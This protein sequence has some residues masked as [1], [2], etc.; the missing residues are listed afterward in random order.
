MSAKVIV[1]GVDVAKDWHYV[2]AITA[3]SGVSVE[4]AF[5]ISNDWSGFDV[6]D[7]SLEAAARARRGGRAD[8]IVGMEPTGVY[9]QPLAYFLEQMGYH[10]VYVNPFAV[11]Q[12]KEVADNTPVKSDPKDALVI[13][14][15][16]RNGHYLGM[17][18]P[19]GVYADMRSLSDTHRERRKDR[20]RW[21]N[22]M[23][24]A[25]AR[26][27]PEFPTVMRTLDSDCAVW[28]LKNAPTPKDLLAIDEEAL[29][30]GL[31]SMYKRS[32]I[33]RQ[34]ARRLR[35]AAAHSI[36]IPVG[37][38]ARLSLMD[39][40]DQLAVARRR[41]DECE[42]RMAKVLDKAGTPAT[43]MLTI[44]G[45]GPVIAVHLLGRLGDVRQYEHPR[46]VVK[47]AGMNMTH[48]SSG[49]KDGKRHLS[50]RGSALIRATVYQA[51]L[52][53]IR[54]DP[55]MRAIYDE[56]RTKAQSPLN[57]TSALC[58]I[59]IRLLK[60]IWGMS[61]HESAYDRK[62]VLAHHHHRKAA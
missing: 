48:N 13:A 5:R 57:G 42:Q 34:R 21:A 25:L 50:K 22:R 24:T 36:G 59:G 49:T 47:M 12:T 3:A 6:L 28:V 43:L 61:R 27:F 19:K 35:D 11:K 23:R 62:I 53:V 15:L 17:H 16:V 37:E 31:G 4:K 30:R 26:Y 56:L 8:V 10:V 2:Q 51:A 39:L 14:G 20:N 29:A 18:L 38:Q 32:R 41:L 33:E 45:V 40:A 46:Q 9:G 58:A 60:V 55:A 52:S 1:V 7:R 44:P 54:A